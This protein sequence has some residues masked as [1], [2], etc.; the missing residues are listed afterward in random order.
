MCTT[1]LCLSRVFQSKAFVTDFKTAGFCITFNLI[2][3]AFEKLGHLDLATSKD[4]RI[5]A[6]ISI[7]CFHPL[8]STFRR[9]NLVSY[10]EV[11]LETANSLL[12][13]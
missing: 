6:A 5:F 8:Y 10:P 3:L 7:F 11:F 1:R 4:T 2:V 12:Q 13:S 9:Y